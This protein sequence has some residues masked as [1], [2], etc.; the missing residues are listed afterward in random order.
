MNKLKDNKAINYSQEILSRK[1]IKKWKNAGDK[2][3]ECKA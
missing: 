3:K 1:T 2:G